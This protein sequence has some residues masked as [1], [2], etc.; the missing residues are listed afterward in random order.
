MVQRIV[1]RARGKARRT[2]HARRRFEPLALIL[3]YHQICERDVDP[4]N[5]AVTPA[6]F[7]EQLAVLEQFA[8]PV[9][10]GEIA[11]AAESGSFAHLPRRAVAIT[12]DDGYANNLRH[13]APALVDAKMPGTV[14]VTTGMVDHPREFW[15]DE[16]ERI[17]LSPGTLPDLLDLAVG[18]TRYVWELGDDTEYTAEQAHEHRRWLAWHT[19]PTSRHHLF[20]ELYD[21]FQ[22]MEAAPRAELLRHLLQW[23]NVPETP[24]ADLDML[25]VSGLRD[26]AAMPGISI[27]AHTV[28][29]PVLAA[30]NADEQ[31]RE[32]VDSRDQLREWLGPQ[33]ALDGMAYPYG[34]SEHYSNVTAD[35]AREVGY[36]WAAANVAD[37]VRPTTGVFDLRRASVTNLNGDAF[38][39]WLRWWFG[40]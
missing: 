27:Q 29:H 10:I 6:N 4:W 32:L 40:L 2:L 30:L 33:A 12:F 23:A 39:H 20:Q 24:R 3:T 31:R 16:L 9:H 17:F 38:Q 25:S 11:A 21:V 1:R 14:F 26:L 22:P 18:S 37:V 34:L 15:N 7:R 19:A 28:S 35:L 5:N 36:R 8:S 13:A